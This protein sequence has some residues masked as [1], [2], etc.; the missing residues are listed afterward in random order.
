M[1]AAVLDGTGIAGAGDDGRDAPT[2]LSN[3]T[4]IPLIELRKI[5]RTFV[6]DGGVEVRALK[7]VDLKIYPGEFVAIVGQSGSGKSTMMNLLGC[8]DRPTSGE[9]FFAGRN[10]E[11]FD[12][13]GLAWLRREAFG[14]VFQSYNLLATESAE[15]NVEV[16][17]IYAGMSADERELR[18]Q[19]LLSSLGLGDRMDHRPNQ[20]SG[21]QQQRVSIARALMNGGNIILADEPTGALDSKSGVEVMALLEELATKGHT[22][23]LITHD[24]EIAEHADRVIEF[25]DGRIVNDSG[26]AE[27]AVDPAKNKALRELFMSRQGSSFFGGLGESVRMAMRSLV[28]NAFRT[29]LTLLGI[30]IGVA[31]VV[32]LLAVGEGAQSDIVS[33]I[34]S[35]GTNVLN[36]QPQRAEGQRRDMPSTLSFEDADAILEGVPNVAYTLPKVSGGQTVRFEREDTR[37]DVIATTETLPEAKSWPLAQGVFFTRQDSEEFNPVAVLGRTVYEELWPEGG[38]P[39]G[40]WVFIG[41]TPFQIIGL[42]TRKGAS[43]NDD[44]DEAIYVPLKAGALRLFGEDIASSIEV[45]VDDVSLISQTEDTLIDFMLERHNGIEDFRIF[46]AA[47]ML[48]TLEETQATFRIFLGAVGGIALLVGGIGVM[49]IML[50]SVTERTREIGVRMATGARKRDILTQFLA[51]AIVVTQVGGVLGVAIGFGLALGIERLPNVSLDV[52]FT[53]TPAIIAFCSAA[54]IGLIFGFAPA[55]KAAQ[56]DPV[57]ALSNE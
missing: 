48:E 41:N 45:I 9:Y 27:G 16:P 57:V 18:A 56:L 44:Q 11:S 7:D 51:E 50:V 17:G 33:R 30:V 20:L 28:A 6:T 8:L 49:N 43:G 21:G 1:T 39:I 37:A 38:D 15:E 10:I 47:E 14:F 36:L 12:S 24:S 5:C 13:D 3:E 23:I 26:H 19:S 40:E 4:A 29:F 2:V 25:R 35:I 53:S 32:A 42:L 46:N 52:V 34:S 31:A 54:A 55:R 22:V